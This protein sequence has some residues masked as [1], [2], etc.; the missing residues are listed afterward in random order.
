[1]RPVHLALAR[2]EGSPVMLSN[3]VMLS[4]AKGLARWVS[5]CFAALSMTS[6]DHPLQQRAISARLPNRSGPLQFTPVAFAHSAPWARA[7]EAG[8]VAGPL[9]Q[10]G[11]AGAAP[12]P[13]ANR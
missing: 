13:T 5:R 6:K 11:W 8:W 4:A 9:S 1:M 3:P 7:L 10:A 2:Q 12:Q